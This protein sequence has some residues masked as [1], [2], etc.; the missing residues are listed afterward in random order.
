MKFEAMNLNPS[1]LAGITSVGYTD[2]TPIQE[3]AIPIALNKSDIL[4]LAQTGT[5][6]TLA[7]LIPIL[8]RLTEGSLGSV[9]ALILAPTRELAEQI[10]QAIIGLTSK[11]NVRSITLYGG[12]HK[13][14][15]VRGLRRGVDI[16]VACPGRLIDHLRDGNID[17]SK[18][19][20]LVLDEADTMCDMGFLPSIRRILSYLP[21]DRQTL[22]FAATMPKDIR[23]LADEILNNP[24]PVQ[25]GI[26]APADTV[27]HSIYPITDAKKK[28]LL[29]DL[30]KHT[31]LG[32]VIIFTRTKHRAKELAIDLDIAGY[33]VAELQGNLSQNRRQEAIDGFRK[34][35]YDLLVAT[36]IASRGID[37]LDISYVINFDMPQTVDAYIHRI[38]RTGRAQ[39]TGE[40]LTLMLSE[41]VYLVRQIERVLGKQ[42]ERFRLPDFEYGKFIEKIQN[43][44]IRTEIQGIER[45]S[46][47]SN[48]PRRED[49]R[50]SDSSNAPQREDNR[51][52]DSSN[53]PRRDD[54]SRT[55][56]YGG[57]DRSSSSAP[58][59]EDNR[60]SDSS[61]APRRDDNSR[62][63]SY[64]G[65]DRS[66]S[67]APRRDDNRSPSRTGSYGGRD[68]SSSSAPRR[69]DNRSPSRTGFSGPRRDG[70]K[71]PSRTKKKP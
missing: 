15:Q 19:D 7:F 68:R 37:V 21:K 62:T 18:V 28:T 66:S 65:R 27:S 22:F 31:A 47:S 51:S 46:S 56:S 14:P 48:A 60:S 10:H 20:T 49:N 6:K 40:A 43:V 44:K 16:I 70:N 4:G 2:T 23:I 24:I 64:G 5:G 12:V 53:A 42:I 71:P 3:K 63:G 58:R 1:V 13:L 67:S 39:Q 41:D 61:N 32:R 45:V 35:K 52:S 29:M 54:N 55:G 57:R 36:D 8:Q 26:I 59:R 30:L 33:R 50:S 11:S 9:R 17:L 34:G 25:V 38:G 69:D